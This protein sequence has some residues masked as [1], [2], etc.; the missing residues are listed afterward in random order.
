[1]LPENW[2]NKARAKRRVV[3]I[4]G[5]RMS[6]SVAKKTRGT[7]EMTTKLFSC[8]TPSRFIRGAEKAK[9]MPEMK[10]ASLESPIFL[11]KR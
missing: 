8:P 3:I 2:R 6:A 11:P 4:L 7:R 1:M 10:L 5:L 9:M